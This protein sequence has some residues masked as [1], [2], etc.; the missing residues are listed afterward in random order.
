MNT[1]NY[2]A[3]TEADAVAKIMA[4]ELISGCYIPKL[5]LSGQQLDKPLRLEKCQVGLLNLVNATISDAVHCNEV[6]FLDT[7][8][9]GWE[10]IA[11]KHTVV[12]S[13]SLAFKNCV[14]HG[15][16]LFGG[17]EFKGVSSFQ[18][19]TYHKRAIFKNT[20]FHQQAY[21]FG[22]HF[23]GQVLFNNAVFALEG[24]FGGCNFDVN[25][26]F[27]NAKFLEREISFNEIKTNGRMNFNGVE[28]EGYLTFRNAELDGGM[29][30]K[31]ASFHKEADFSETR[32]HKRVMFE[33]STFEQTAD[34][35]GCYFGEQASFDRAV[36]QSAA[37]FRKICCSQELNAVDANFGEV[38][39]DYANINRRLDL[40]NSKASGFC[41]YKAAVDLITLEKQQVRRK[42]I[43][44]NPQQVHYDR[45]KEEYL[46][47]KNSFYQRGLHE[48]EDW[49]YRKF[50][51][52][53]R[54][55]QTQKAWQRITGKNKELGIIAAWGRL[56]AN[57]FSRIII[58]RG[59]GYG[60]QPLNITIVAISFIILF[61]CIYSTFPDGLVRPA[62][63]P[64][65]F[66]QG[67]YFSFAT[68]TTM[69][70]GDIQPR[71]DSYMRYLVSVEAF[72]GLFI[73]TLF[74]GTYTRKIIR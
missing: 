29:N 3:M 10:R 17:A 7:V 1:Q 61:G 41:F 38:F 13:N 25:S 6:T 56:W 16:V 8:Y 60:T 62:D 52:M 28:V 27:E 15:D 43:N 14:F 4:G 12:F 69:G 18:E 26:S 63:M 50:R 59:T 20:Y 46:L 57:F 68:F 67:I 66:S 24:Y 23:A 64:F 55:E 47:I 51:Q 42:L 37:Y 44:E 39:F 2:T 35:T 70:F 22:S 34:F 74:V 49:A 58:D 45:V 40:S 65:G 32:F 19:S 53:K 48:E 72:L 36:F 31:K 21:F 11:Q 9:C 71:L 73:M 54:K 33:E 30:F 5:D